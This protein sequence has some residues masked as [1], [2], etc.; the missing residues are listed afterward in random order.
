MCICIAKAGAVI[1]SVLNHHIFAKLQNCLFMAYCYGLLSG[2][3]CIK[4]AAIELQ[5]NAIAAASGF[6]L[7]QHNWQS[8]AQVF[9]ISF[10]YTF[11]CSES[12]LETQKFSFKSHRVLNA[13]L[14]LICFIK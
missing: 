8:F 9:E 11:A 4:F 2:D 5:L 10:C 6:R 3:K 12:F 7:L 13:L 14:S 1:I